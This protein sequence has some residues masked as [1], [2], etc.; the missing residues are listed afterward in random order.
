MP[1]IDLNREEMAK[2]EAKEEKPLTFECRL[3]REKKQKIEKAN[4]NET[5]SITR[6]NS[7]TFGCQKKKEKKRMGIYIC[8]VIILSSNVYFDPKFPSVI[9]ESKIVSCI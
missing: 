9:G 2:M 8:L 3:S 4:G 7:P 1:P 5:L 6:S